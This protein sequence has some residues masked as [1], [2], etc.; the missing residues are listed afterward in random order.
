MGLVI[1]LHDSYHTS[2]GIQQT[3]V[4]IQFV[5]KF[6]ITYSYAFDEYKWFGV[7]LWVEFCVWMC[8]PLPNVWMEWTK[9]RVAVIQLDVL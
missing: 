1:F 8:V 3:E 9:D 7:N 2:F 4:M 6:P 5:E